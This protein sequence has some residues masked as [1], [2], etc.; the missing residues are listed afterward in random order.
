[1]SVPAPVILLPTNGKDYS[2]DV[3]TQTISGTTSTDTASITVNG[4]EVGVSYTAGEAVWSWMGTLNLGDNILTVTAVEKTTLIPSIP[5]VINITYVNATTFITVSPP[6]GVKLQEYQNQIKSMTARNPEMQTVGYNFYVSTRSGGIPG[7]GSNNYAL[8]NSTLVTEYSD[9]VQQTTLLNQAVEVAGTI[10]VT[11]MTEEVN[12]IYYYSAILDQPTFNNLVSASLIDN[13]PFNQNTPLFFVI[14]AVIYDPVAGQVTESANS[15]EL[16]GSPIVITTGLTDLPSR[17]QNDIMTTFGNEMLA[18]NSGIDTKPGTVLRDNDDPVS[19]EMARMYVI[20]DFLA[21]SLSVSALLAF[22]DTTGNGQSDPVSTSPQKRALQLALNLTNATDVQTL[23]D[24]QFDFLG[25]N[26]N[27]IRGPAQPAVG[28]VT[29]FIETTPV[30]DMYAYEGGIVST[31]GDIDSGIASVTYRLMTSKVLQASNAASYYNTS[32]KR[33]ELSVNVSAVNP[34]SAGNTASYTVVTVNSGID[35][36][37]QVENPNPISFGTDEETNAQIGGRIQL[38]M[39]TDTGT[40]GGYMKTV[41]AVPGVQDVRVE[42]AGDALMIRDYDPVRNIHIGGKVDIYVQGERVSQVSDKVALSFSSVSAQG[43]ITGEIFEIVNAVSFQFKTLNPQV[44]ANTP[45]F[46]VDRVHNATRGKDYDLTGYQII[47]DGTTIDLNELLPLNVSVGLASE[48]V[49]TVDYKFRNSNTFIL[50]NQPVMD[51][52]SVVGQISGTLPPENYQLIKLQDP[53]A[54]GGSTIAQ[55]GVQIL[56]VNGLPLTEFQTVTNE[57][58]SLIV[59]QP[60]SLKYLG[61]D[62]TSIVV[63]NTSSTVTYVANTDYRV[64]PGTDEVATAIQ[65]IE[66]GNILNG[67]QVYV[68]YT[69]IE[70]FT[71]T[72]TTNSLLDDVQTQVD[73][74]KHACADVIVKQAIENSVDFV[75]TVIPK[76]TVT[77]LSFLTSQIRTAVSNYISQLPMGSP[78]TQSAV[79]KVV[80]GISD[81]SSIIIPFNR[82]V[83][84]NG[85]FIIRDDIGETSFQ[86]YNV[87]AVT[88][89]VTAGPALTY[90]TQDQGGPSNYFRGVF[91]N[92]I[93]LALQTDP[94]NVSGAAGRAYI[95]SDGHIIVS[96][97]DGLLPDTKDYSVA[98]FVYGE[99]GS[100]DINTASLEYLTVGNFTVIYDQA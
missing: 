22:D 76:Q 98:Y 67:Q 11:T 70:N 88:A 85:D 72:Y 87:G 64:I 47:G 94:A 38:A 57:L 80:Q 48:D 55:D 20:Q 66:A 60:S 26:V 81:V 96:T 62:P 86:V 79:I 78:L 97:L 89:Y 84:S 52:I 17:T 53:L 3:A 83:K 63:T 19:E 21:R 91:E 27:V 2:T 82:M 100:K 77:N 35:S 5:A 6:T 39:F 43:T 42:K 18:D 15:V 8:I 16:Q 95:R 75:M 61:A 58:H 4:A 51:V 32:T 56:F 73:L 49:I 99:T 65:I 24:N 1:M 46:E 34:G 54:N 69:A 14:T 37:F 59:G 44:T 41:V 36:D 90:A 9:F 23:I 13:V 74:M 29:F 50:Q 28:T 68:S 25:S 71:I 30:R 40:W 93:A 92:E 10:K 31:V 7:V 33:Y 45:I 12:N